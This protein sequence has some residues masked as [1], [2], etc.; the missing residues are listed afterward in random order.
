MRLDGNMA[1]A[2]D[3]VPQEAAA[4]RSEQE[5]SVV[6]IEHSMDPNSETTDGA[7]PVDV[8]TVQVMGD[9]GR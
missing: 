5:V 2:R 9:F 7:T 8:R 3:D 6:V 4:A 1:A